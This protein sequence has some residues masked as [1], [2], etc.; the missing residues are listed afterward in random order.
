MWQIW[1]HVWRQP[2][3]YRRF[4]GGSLGWKVV[5]SHCK[6]SHLQAMQLWRQPQRYHSQGL[7][8]FIPAQ[9]AQRA[10]F[11]AYEFNRQHMHTPPTNGQVLTQP[12]HMHLLLYTTKWYILVPR[13]IP[14][15][16]QLRSPAELPH[17]VHWGAPTSSLRRWL[18]LTDNVNLAAKDLAVWEELPL[19]TGVFIPRYPKL[20]Q[21]SPGVM[22]TNRKIFQ[23]I[24]VAFMGDVR[25]C[26]CYGWRAISSWDQSSELSCPYD[27]SLTILVVAQ[28]CLFLLLDVAILGKLSG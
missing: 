10:S 2:Y 27:L 17:S 21:K 24:Y 4:L 23:C 20:I 15:P 19:E 26:S 14:A 5:V 7:I 18:A 16:S 11:V 1:Q 28:S 9:H 3:K 13:Q 6:V 25:E 12:F 22:H 8:T